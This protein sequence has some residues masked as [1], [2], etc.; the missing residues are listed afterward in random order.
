M[1]ETAGW[2]SLNAL[3]AP[4]ADAMAANA[5]RL[6]LVVSLGSLGERLIDAGAKATGGMEA[7]RLIGEICMAGLGHVTCGPSFIESWPVG[8]TVRSSHPVAACLASQYAGWSLSDKESGSKYSV[9]GSGPGRAMAA[10]EE[11]F[12]EL[13]YRDTPGPATFVLETDTPPPESLVAKIAANCGVGAGK[14]T[15]IYAPT[16]SLAGSF[17]VVARVL[18]V[19]LHKAHALKFSL[20]DIVDGIGTAPLSPPSPDFL[21][22]MGRTNDAIIFGGHVHLFVRGSDEAAEALALQM[23]SS[24]SRDYGQPFA[25][26]FAGYKHDFYAI[27]PMLFSPAA[28]SITALDSGRTFRAGA[29][30]LDLLERSFTE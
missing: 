28:V 22:A 4:L 11:L 13:G 12:A 7:G 24:A 17:Q 20:G 25:K 19:A 15:F 16:Q 1:V 18:E 26:V 27:D 6:R 8:I 21:K 14:L 23:P 10:R 5:D 30:A 2:P 29:L 9:L 3:A